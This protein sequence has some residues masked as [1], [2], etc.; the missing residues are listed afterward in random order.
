MNKSKR[1]S[2]I[3]YIIHIYEGKFKMHTDTLTANVIKSLT[4]KQRLLEK[5]LSLKVFW[6][7]SKKRMNFLPDGIHKF[8]IYLFTIFGI[9][10][11]QH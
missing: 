11:L 10:Y 9:F 4:N 7:L 2:Y 5:Y 3:E 6:H 1:R 8:P